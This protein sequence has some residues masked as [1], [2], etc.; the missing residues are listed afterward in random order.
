MA[1]AAAVTK[2]AIGDIVYVP[3]PASFESKSDLSKGKILSAS[4]IPRGVGVVYKVQLPGEAEDALGDDVEFSDEGT[5]IWATECMLSNVNCLQRVAERV[6]GVREHDCNVLGCSDECERPKYDYCV[7][8]DG[9]RPQ[10]STWESCIQR[11]GLNLASKGV[12]IITAQGC[13]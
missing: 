9:M 13:W 10:C 3:L 4:T 2:Y 8:W 12:I 6:K 7:K 1:E 5:E 11:I